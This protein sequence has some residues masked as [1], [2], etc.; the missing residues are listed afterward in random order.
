MWAHTLCNVMI[1]QRK[2]CRGMRAVQMAWKTTAVMPRADI[3][4]KNHWRIDK[5]SPFTDGQ[6][7]QIRNTAL[8]IIQWI[9]YHRQNP[10]N[11][12]ETGDREEPPLKVWKCMNL[13]RLL[14]YMAKKK[15]IFFVSIFSTYKVWGMLV[16]QRALLKKVFSQ[17]VPI[18]IEN[19]V[20]FFEINQ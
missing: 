16:R 4:S 18:H 6:C 8:T 9:P 17:Y 2:A 3:H 20:L 10:E 7:S 19:N 13:K 5:V 12:L 11:I 14:K 15:L 1:S